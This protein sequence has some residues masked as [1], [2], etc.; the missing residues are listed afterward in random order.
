MAK[1]LQLDERLNEKLPILPL[2]PPP[3]RRYVRSFLFARRIDAPFAQVHLI[4]RVILALCLSAA[5]LRTIN[6]GQPDI[7]G[8][9]LLWCA[10]LCVFLLS[11]ISARVVRLYA[12]LTLPSLLA[13]FVTWVIFNP[14]PGT[15]T[16]LRLPVYAG[17]LDIA[18]APWQGVLLILIGGYFLWTRRLLLGILVGILAAFMVAHWMSLPEWR[19]AQVAFFHP[20]TVLISDKGLLTAIT[21]VI[22]YAG[23]VLAT[24]A[25][26]VTARDVELIGA[27]RQLHVPHMVIFF[28][29]TVFRSLDLAL[30]DYDTIH[31]AQVARAI[32]ARPRSFLRRLRDLASIAV[33]MV[34]MMIRRSSEIGDA[35]LARGYTPGRPDKDFYETSPWRLIDWGVVVLSLC[36]LYL[37]LMP[38][39]TVTTLLWGGQL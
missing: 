27:L 28:L 21:K 7:V 5:L 36:L 26:V 11:G 12:L 6:T 3:G 1:P 20:L 23:M 34:A 31:Q 30:A 13:I 38:H 8:A 19:L 14:I 17:L 9:S 18:L 2:L 24:I 33:P 39:P 35:L 22:G 16:L 15:V 32:L 37:A 29:A 25:L 10:A 4:A